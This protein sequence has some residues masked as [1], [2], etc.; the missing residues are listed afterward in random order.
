M[1]AFWRVE[2]Y[3]Q[4]CTSAG[5]VSLAIINTEKGKATF[6][7]IQDLDSIPSARRDAF[8]FNPQI[9]HTSEQPEEWETVYDNLCFMPFEKYAEEYLR[10]QSKMKD[11]FKLIISPKMKMNLKKM[12]G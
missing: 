12:V 4:E 11:Y 6:E 7:A 8:A 1:G 3:Y 5:G 9:T 2:R 10:V